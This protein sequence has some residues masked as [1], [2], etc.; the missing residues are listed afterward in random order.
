MA[1]MGSLCDFVGPPLT[2]EVTTGLIDDAPRYCDRS[3]LFDEVQPFAIYLRDY[4]QVTVTSDMLATRDSAR[5]VGGRD[6]FL[7]VE[8]SAFKRILS[9]WRERGFVDA[10]RAASNEDPQRITRVLHWTVTK[11]KWTFDAIERT[12]SRGEGIP[13][14]RY[15]S[16]ADIATTRD[17]ATAPIRCLCWHPHCARLAVATKDDRIRVFSK[18]TSGVAILRHSAQKSVCS[19]SWRPNAGRELA[20]ACQTGV[21]IWTV[22][23]GVA[24]NSLSHALLLRQRNHSPVTNVAW[25]PQG[26]L[27][28]S[29]SPADMNMLVWDVSREICVP[30]KRIGGNGL[31]FARWSPCGSRLFS[32]TSRAIFR[33]WNTGK[34]TAWDAEKWKV[35][36]GRVADACFGPHLTLLFTS[37]EDPATVFSLP[38]QENI[39]D[40]KDTIVPSGIKIAVPLID[41]SR[42]YFPTVDG[43]ISVGGRIV[44]M[45]WDP[46]GKYLAIIFR[47]SPVVVLYRTRAII[48]SRITDVSPGCIIKGF[49]DEVPDCMQ[50]YQNYDPDVNSICLT[51]AWSSG[52]VQHFPI[53]FSSQRVTSRSM[54][55]TTVRF[56]S[57]NLQDISLHNYSLSH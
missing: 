1:K 47:D 49:S 41:L 51:I 26:D 56:G 16:V 31:C 39:F 4:P 53:V 21:L 10:I 5:T 40:V 12:I 27:L 28:I 50:F 19:V 29:C 18:G 42:V 54:H 15:E 33:V 36:N 20:A 17:W 14:S 6:L 3:D 35:P 8:D 2:G 43:E 7:P 46:S 23:L 24:S 30:F 57:S 48:G 22:E 55:S 37:T 11:L 44:A 45:D 9:V 32:A 38:L 13:T 25:H 52:R 34:G